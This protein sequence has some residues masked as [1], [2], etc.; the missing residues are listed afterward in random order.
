MVDNIE[1][2][3]RLEA[4]FNELR[5]RYNVIP[6]K[7]VEV[8]EILQALRQPDAMRSAVIEECAKVCED[9]ACSCCWTEDATEL[10]A[11]LQDKIRELAKEIK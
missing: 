1:L 6:L 10:A 3:D 2:A 5:K 11:H 4:T 9:E 7:Y 8:R